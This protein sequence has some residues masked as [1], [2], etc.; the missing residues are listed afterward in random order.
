MDHPSVFVAI[1]AMDELHTLPLLLQDLSMQENTAALHVRVCVNQPDDYW[2]LPEKQHVCQQ[3]QLLMDWLRNQSPLP[4]HLLDFASR[5]KG[6]H[7]KHF[8]VGWARKKLFE[9]ICEKAQAEDILISLDADTRIRPGYVHSILEN[10]HKN[11]QIPAISVPYYHTLDASEDQN[12]AMLRYEFYMRNYALNLLRIGSPYG[13][14]A[15]GSAIAMR[16]G[17]LCKIGGITPLQSGEDFYLLQKFRKM[18]PIGLYNRESVYPAPRTSNRVVFGTGPAISKGMDGHWSAYP[19]YH[20][21]LLAPIEESYRKLPDLFQQDLHSDFLDF[22]QQ[23]VKSSQ[24]SPQTDSL[25]TRIRANTKDL[26]HFEQA[27]HEKADGLRILQFLRLQHK[28]YPMRDEQA[29]FENLKYWMPSDLPDWYSAKLSFE[30]YTVEQLNQLRNLLF[31]EE[32][33]W[34]KKSV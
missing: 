27:F 18:A 20:H 28:Q 32:M 24:H 11:P 12:R 5:G 25:W 30:D 33:V 31:E 1:P 8:G 13:F 23:T 3:N 7:G 4:V 29:L 34:R 2:D 17:A 6:W 21:S 22:L 10:F 19:I 9:S 15:L 16:V 14:T 26:P